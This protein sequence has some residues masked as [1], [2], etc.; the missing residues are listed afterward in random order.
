LEHN[1]EEPHHANA[2]SSAEYVRL[3]K[4]LELNAEIIRA[5]SQRATRLLAEQSARPSGDEMRT[6]IPQTKR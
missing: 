1:L 5:L 6:R 2:L 3:K 4:T